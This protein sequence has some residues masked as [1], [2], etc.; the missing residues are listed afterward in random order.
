MI[1][2]DD[3]QLRERFTA[4]RR[5]DAASMPAFAATV[6]A[7]RARRTTPVRGRL[8]LLATGATLAALALVFAIRG[9]SRQAAFDLT[10]VRLHAPTDFLLKLPG[11]DVLRTVPRLGR[12]SLDWR[13][14]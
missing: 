14:L 8:V 7:A 10:A 12:V 4:L 6:A 11:A 5:E 13:T 1:E 2:H 9:R 3:Q